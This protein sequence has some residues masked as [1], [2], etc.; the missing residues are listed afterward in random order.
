MTLQDKFVSQLRKDL[1]EQKKGLI[2]E[3]VEEYRETLN[4]T[5]SDVVDRFVDSIHCSMLSQTDPFTMGQRFELR[6]NLGDEFYASRDTAKG[7]E[8]KQQE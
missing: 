6:I 4:A 2:E 8:D 1:E 3:A 5:L 7:N